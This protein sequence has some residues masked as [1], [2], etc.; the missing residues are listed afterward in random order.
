MS[1]NVFVTRRI[2]QPGL[3]LINEHCDNVEINQ[4]DR[5]L[6]HDELL[7]GVRGRDGVLCLLT[8]TINDD[9]FDA[10]GP[11]CK[12]FAN[13]AVGYNNIDI[14]AAKQRDIR[15]TNTPGVLTD[16]TAD[17]A[18]ALLFSAARRIVESD[19]FM[20][21]GRW[22]GWGPMQFLGQDITGATLGVI[23][24]GRIGANFALKSAGFGMNVL[25]ADPN[26]NEELEE[27]VGATRVE[28]DDLL[29]QADFVSIHVPLMPE[30]THLIG[31]RELSLMK[32]NAVLI[33]TSRGPVVDEKALLAA[34]KE[35]RI[36]AAGLDVYEEEPKAVEGLADLPNVVM[37]PHIASA[38][39]ATRTKMALMAAEN[40][41]AVLRGEQPPNPV[42]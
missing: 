38:T 26:R 8:D 10:A 22:Q 40:L 13:Y 6:T 24:G 3:D 35:E 30:T 33:N 27:A 11:Q 15:I 28:M 17:M 7:E 21:T 2:P 31:E 32:P 9:V 39:V 42:V 18:W 12:V 34:L 14:E 4:E 16:A 41:L 29:K 37:C 19:R 23:G 1:W 25:Y 36:A 5:V 20:R